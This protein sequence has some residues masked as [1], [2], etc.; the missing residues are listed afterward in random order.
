LLSEFRILPKLT[1]NAKVYRAARW[2]YECRLVC[3][4]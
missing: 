4:A 3:H 2:Q 1:L